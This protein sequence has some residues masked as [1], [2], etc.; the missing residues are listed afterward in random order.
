MSEGIIKLG[1]V[2]DGLDKLEKAI[3][4][5]K[6]YREELEKLIGKSGQVVNLP[7]SL[8]AKKVLNQLNT[9]EARFNLIREKQNLGIPIPDAFIKSTIREVEKLD[10]MTDKMYANKKRGEEESA[11]LSKQRAEEDKRVIEEK[12]KLEEKLK[13][14]KKETFEV[15]KSS[16]P[17]QFLDNYD[18]EIKKLD[19][20]KT[21]QQEISKIN[22]EHIQQAKQ[23]LNSG[24][25]KQDVLNTLASQYPK[26]QSGLLKKD[27]LE[28]YKQAKNE[29]INK[30]SKENTISL[31]SLLQSTLGTNEKDNKNISMSVLTSFKENKKEEIILEKQLINEVKEENKQLEK[32]SQILQI[33][34]NTI[35]QHINEKVSEKEKIIGSR[36]IDVSKLS[37]EELRK[38]ENTL[39]NKRILDLKT[40]ARNERMEIEK[41]LLIPSDI[42]HIKDDDFLRLPGF[43]SS[44]NESVKKL[45]NLIQEK[46]KKNEAFVSSEFVKEE[47]YR[48]L[49]FDEQPLKERPLLNIPRQ[50]SDLSKAFKKHIPDPNIKPLTEE[51][52][53]SLMGS[54]YV[55]KNNI[56]NEKENK[57][58]LEEEEKIIQ[59]VNNHLEKRGNFT[60]TKGFKEQLALLE[61]ER[62]LKEKDIQNDKTDLL[63]QQDIKKELEKQVNLMT[64]MSG[65]QGQ[66]G[67]GSQLLSGI[68][69]AGM[70]MGGIMGMLPSMVKGS[71]TPSKEVLKLANQQ[72]TN[73]LSLTGGIMGGIPGL[74]IGGFYGG[75]LPNIKNYKE[76]LNPSKIEDIGPSFQSITTDINL[77]GNALN[78]FGQSMKAVGMSALEEAGTWEILRNKLATFTNSAEEAH[79]RFQE[80]VKL[81]LKTPFEVKG[82]IQAEIL[83]RSFGNNAKA[84]LPKV[85][86]LASAMGKDVDKAAYAIA[87]AMS[88]ASLGFLMLQKT[89]GVSYSKLKELG[90]EFK[91]NGQIM[92]GSLK[93]QNALALSLDTLSGSAERLSRT[94]K[95]QLSNL[96]DSIDVLKESAGKTL[97]PLAKELTDKMIQLVQALNNIPGPVKQFVVSIAGV[98]GAAAL[99]VGGI[100]NFTWQLG[101]FVQ[102]LTAVKSVLPGFIKEFRKIGTIMG[103]ASK[104]TKALSVEVQTMGA[105]VPGAFPALLGLRNVFMGAGAAGAAGAG[106]VAA[107]TA[108]L[109]PILLIGAAVAGTIYLITKA[110]QAYE[111]QKQ[112][113]KDDELALREINRRTILA[114]LDSKLHDVNNSQDAYNKLMDKGAIEVAMMADSEKIFTQ[115]LQL[116][117]MEIQDQEKR[118]EVL[119]Q[120]WTDAIEAKKA[121]EQGKLDEKELTPGAQKVANIVEQGTKFF[122]IDSIVKRSVANVMGAPGFIYNI[123]KSAVKG[124]VKGA[125]NLIVQD[126]QSPEEK[127]RIEE[128]EKRIPQEREKEITSIR[129]ELNSPNNL[130][131]TKFNLFLSKDEEK[132]INKLKDRLKILEDEKYVRNEINRLNEEHIKAIEN[133]ENKEKE[134]L[135]E[136]KRQSNEIKYQQKEVA[137]LISA[138]GP[139]L[140]AIQN[141]IDLQKQKQ[142]IRPEVV[143]AIIGNLEAEKGKLKTDTTFD[144]ENFYRKYKAKERAFAAETGHNPG[145][146]IFEDNKNFTDEQRKQAREEAKKRAQDELDKFNV[147]AGISSV[148]KIT[149]ERFAEI[150]DQLTKRDIIDKNLTTYKAFRPEDRWGSFK[151]LEGEA[152]KHLISKD[153][154]EREKYSKSLQESFDENFKLDWDEFNAKEEEALGKNEITQKQHLNNLEKFISSHGERLKKY[155]PAKYGQLL[156]DFNKA[157]EEFNKKEYKN[158]LNMQKD[159]AKAQDNKKQEIELTKRLELFALEEE[160]NE[161]VKFAGKS[162][163]LDKWYYNQK[164][165]IEQK[166]HE[167]TIKELQAEYEERVALIGRAEVAA[168]KLGTFGEKRAKENERFL[169][170]QANADVAYMEQKRDLEKRLDGATLQ[171]KSIL[172]QNLNNLDKSYIAEKQKR[173][174]EHLLNLKQLA[175]DELKSRAELASATSEHRH[176]TAGISDS[177]YIQEQKTIT[178]GIVNELRDEAMIYEKMVIKGQ[179]LNEVQK[180]ILTTYQQQEEKLLGLNQLAMEQLIS[181]KGMMDSLVEHNKKMGESTDLDLLKQQKKSTEDILRANKTLADTYK[182]RLISGQQLTDTEFNIL[183]TYNQQ[184]EKLKEINTTLEYRLNKEGQIY[185][186]AHK[187]FEDKL[188]LAISEK[189]ITE[190]IANAQRAIYIEKQIEF[191]KEKLAL[192]ERKELTGKI[193]DAEREILSIMRQRKVE[194]ANLLSNISGFNDKVRN[195]VS[196][197]A[198]LSYELKHGADVTGVMSDKF[199]SA[200]E[201]AKSLLEQVKTIGNITAAGNSYGTMGEFSSLEDMVKSQGKFGANKDNAAKWKAEL[202]IKHDMGNK[203]EAD[204]I[205]AGRK[206]LEKQR[207]ELQKRLESGRETESVM[208]SLNEEIKYLDKQLVDGLANQSVQTMDVTATTVNVNGEES[209]GNKDNEKGIGGGGGTVKTG[210]GEEVGGNYS[211]KTTNPTGQQTT[212]NNIT[213]EGSST[214]KS[215]I[216]VKPSLNYNTLPVAEQQALQESLKLASW[217]GRGSTSSFDDAGNYIQNDPNNLKTAESSITRKTGLEN[218]AET[219]GIYG[220]G[221][222]YYDKLELTRKLYDN[223]HENPVNDRNANLS[224]QWAIKKINKSVGDYTLNFLKGMV[225]QSKDN[226]KALSSNQ[227][228]NY[229]N[230]RSSKTENNYTINV[231]GR[232]TNI[233]NGNNQRIV[234]DFVSLSLAGKTLR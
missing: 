225:S 210:E 158:S 148:S 126:K 88:G 67:K 6:N 192:L 30:N 138:Y 25:K 133:L 96:Q 84:L 134:I 77:A 171:E 161:R 231:D 59:R 82:L 8:E 61:Q 186:I 111:K 117:N 13:S 100:F 211:G 2:F 79:E 58:I 189:Q 115:A 122:A 194:H 196:Q 57:K 78:L 12:I 127:A 95:G 7:V 172:Y 105:V 49:S 219:T 44:S 166:A 202:T 177:S 130:L 109:G 178:Q 216:E 142:G 226:L 116:Q 55:Y 38:H 220:K 72:S 137:N 89:W 52:L 50:S 232:Q 184:E 43:V 108:A 102:G 150:Q 76:I 129:N 197:A 15:E 46:H 41:K 224:G 221:L 204:P 162:V 86:D 1:I 227:Y 98:G 164:R 147:E 176:K 60:F 63:I 74:N 191:E 200:Y 62:Q 206:E 123:G 167:D 47:D 56:N 103:F 80:I 39:R 195:A 35:K 124:V 234:R 159:I 125:E 119:K 180:N 81:G 233:S 121:Y 199:K 228:S 9:I 156:D 11:R 151:K 17:A 188:N 97:L 128:L 33:I 31:S 40:K 73:A 230:Q 107:F 229:N 19:E 207:A 26:E 68:S 146:I 182:I 110:L 87:R 27:Y 93:T 99:A 217:K 85:V 198:I 114:E 157:R 215:G 170:E 187:T 209:G 169:N 153:A 120:K 24:Y 208:K 213:A 34:G 20:I 90:A 106:G 91:A 112:Q 54:Q 149:P 205:K 21:K 165:E 163:E 223:T 135:E 203:D 136:K 16:H 144:E 139:L 214:I 83:L 218:L 28:I 154:G 37:E 69:F 143:N 45:N 174:E 131:A 23:L 48:F 168:E 36:D 18:K 160:Y 4:L 173:Y 155:N 51:E 179:E 92:A 222:S 212:A 104:G 118:I 3:P 193:T 75:K 181:R 190:D 145:E 5:T 185:D 141:I 64:Q 183:N 29:I 132:Y 53:K 175:L 10:K 22:N 113:A 101:N 42:S 201:Y 14:K 140:P 71:Y 32:K 152:G 65:K 66:F 94:Y 70:N